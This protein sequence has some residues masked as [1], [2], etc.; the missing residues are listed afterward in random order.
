MH[1]HPPASH[2]FI[3]DAN[4]IRLFLTE[5]ER[6]EGKEQG[7]REV[8]VSPTELSGGGAVV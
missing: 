3:L 1:N 2:S 6:E 8:I 4:K 5:R 7:G